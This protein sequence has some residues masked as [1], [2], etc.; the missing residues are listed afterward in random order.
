MSKFNPFSKQIVVP[1]Q[2]EVQLRLAYVSCIDKLDSV[3]NSGYCEYI[4]PPI[5]KYGTL[6]FQDFDEIKE[7]GYRH[8]ETY[9]KGFKKAGLMKQFYWSNPGARRG[10]VYTVSS[11]LRRGSIDNLASLSLGSSVES[12]ASGS[13]KS[14]W[15]EM[16]TTLNAEAA[17]S[18]LPRRRS[19]QQH[20]RRVAALSSDP[21]L[22]E[23]YDD[24]YDSG[25]MDASPT[26]RTLLTSGDFDDDDDDMY[27]DDEDIDS[28]N[29]ITDEEDDNESGFLSQM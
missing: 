10:S 6:Q 20:R 17:N 25:S 5:E 19:S 4:R 2:A 13:P 15:A 11:A 29:L 24:D 26:R 12:N 27:E 8:G 21:D 22:S 28:D 18:L 16:M 7:V 1:N 14:N 3:K 9:F 23:S